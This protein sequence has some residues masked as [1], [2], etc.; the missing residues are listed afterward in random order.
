MMKQLE[1]KH[2]ELKADAEKLA[3]SLISQIPLNDDGVTRNAEAVNQMRGALAEMR[4]EARHALDQIADD[5]AESRQAAALAL[6]AARYTSRQFEAK[7]AP[8]HGPGDGDG[9]HHHRR[10]VRCPWRALQTIGRMVGRKMQGLKGIAS[11]PGGPKM[12]AERIKMHQRRF[13]ERCKRF[14]GANMQHLH[15]V[16]RASAADGPEA[17]NCTDEAPPTHTVDEQGVSKRIGATGTHPCPR[18]NRPLMPVH[19]GVVCDISGMSPIKGPRYHLLGKNYDLCEEEFDKLEEQDKC[20][21]VCIAFPGSLPE[22]CAA[23]V[24][25]PA[26]APADAGSAAPLYPQLPEPAV[27]L[28]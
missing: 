25:A 22:K 6:A 10:H 11:P 21:Y 9:Q 17:A 19:R 12:V 24:T 13:N 1:E 8:T 18:E 16:G 27:L 15:L 7:F 3:A 14:H 23:P 2:P 5:D 4:K 20:N 28:C 26:P